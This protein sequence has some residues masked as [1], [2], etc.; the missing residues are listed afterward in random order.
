VPKHEK[1]FVIVDF[2]Y[3][4]RFLERYRLLYSKIFV[5]A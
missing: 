5:M 4:K 3:L 1:Y 2:H